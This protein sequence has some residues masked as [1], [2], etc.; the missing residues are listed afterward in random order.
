MQTYASPYSALGV[1]VGDVGGDTWCALDIKE[2]ELAD[3]G[4]ELEEEG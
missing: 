4:V 3:S 1:D 2:R